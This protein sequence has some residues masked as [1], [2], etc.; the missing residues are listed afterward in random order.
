MCEFID[1]WNLLFFI[2]SLNVVTVDVEL[3]HYYRWETSV[4]IVIKF[5]A[6]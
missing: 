5:V 6:V 2:L 3:M 4:F 1:L